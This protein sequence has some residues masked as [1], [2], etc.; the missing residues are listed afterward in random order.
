MARVDAAPRFRFEPRAAALS[1][2][3]PAVAVAVGL[4]LGAIVVVA[5]GDDPVTA[6]AALAAGAVG[7][8]QA[9]AAT[10]LRALPIAVAGLGI[11]IALRAGALN[12]GGE[13]QMIV[14]GLASAAAALATAALPAPFGL[15]AALAAGCLAGAAWA[16]L[17]AVL[18][19]RLEVPILITTL[20]L[21][22]VAAL[23][24]AWIVTYPL[25][26]VT[27]G[28]A[29]AAT[30]MIPEA[31]RLPIILPGTRL[32]LGALVVIVL[33]LVAA[34]VFARTVLGYELRM[35]GANRLFAAYGGVDVGRRIVAAMLLSGAVCGLA[36]TLLVVGVNHRYIDTLIT[37]GGFAW[38]GF[39]AAILALGAPVLT[40]IAALFLGGLQVGAAGMARTTDVPLQLADVV[41]AAIILVVAVRPAIRRALARAAR[42]D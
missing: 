25:R 8:G 15:L 37:T 11:A 22:Y 33:P 24:A 1:L 20:L 35:L 18:E 19:T 3:V 40:V 4:A 12:L 16:L 38:S 41:Q 6:Y 42:V 2:A 13:G 9:L 17:P 30:P 21:N 5:S 7:S 27:A 31:A 39:I 14:G 28:A 23:L 26:D 10:I 36:G 29:V 34:W 32:H